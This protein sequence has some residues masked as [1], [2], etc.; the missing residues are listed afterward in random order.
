MS[1]GTGYTTQELDAMQALSEA[2]ITNNL[3]P[4][5]LDCIHYKMQFTHCNAT[6]AYQ[7]LKSDRVEQKRFETIQKGCF[8]VAGI[9]GIL[10]VWWI[11]RCA[12]GGIRWIVANILDRH[13]YQIA[14]VDAEGGC[15]RLD[16]KTGQ[17]DYIPRNP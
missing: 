17:V 11:Y 12:R 15:Y 6:S 4:L 1:I 5:D 8:I 2:G 13:R 7:Q 10:L 16:S 3:E 9:L 14:S